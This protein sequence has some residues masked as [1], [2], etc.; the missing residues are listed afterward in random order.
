MG[1]GEAIIVVAAGIGLLFALLHTIGN[2][3]NKTIK[4][5]SSPV[6]LDPGELLK[7]NTISFDRAPQKTFLTLPK[8]SRI[9]QGGQLNFGS[10]TYL[11]GFT[12]AE[13]PLK[14]EQENSSYPYQLTKEVTL[15]TSNVPVFQ[16]EWV[17]SSQQPRYYKVTAGS[18]TFYVVIP[19]ST[20]TEK[21]TTEKAETAVIKVAVKDS[22][23]FQKGQYVHG[24]GTGNNIHGKVIQVNDN[25]IKVDTLV[26]VEFQSIQINGK[27]DANGIRQNRGSI[28]AFLKGSSE[29]V[30][31]KDMTFKNAVLTKDE[32]GV[33]KLSSSS[34]SPD[35]VRVTL[36]DKTEYTINNVTW[37]NYPE[38]ILRRFNKREGDKFTVGE[39]EVSRT[40]ITENKELKS[41]NIGKYT[42][43]QEL[44][45]SGNE[46]FKGKVTKIQPS[47]QGAQSGPGIITLTRQ[48]DERDRG[49]GLSGT[50]KEVADKSIVI[51]LDSASAQKA[52][53]KNI[54][55]MS[56][57][58]TQIKGGGKAQLR[59]VRDAIRQYEAQS[60]ERQLAARRS[61][62][63]AKRRLMASA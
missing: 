16:F 59:A 25:E 14:G 27:V 24:M 35:I 56:S 52:F 53:P 17:G 38:F 34:A 1:P 44:V 28:N 54:L 57:T 37:N 39:K 51:Q 29:V 63:Q 42:I 40:L 3:N 43:G 36:K 22:S 55:T 31:G 30:I 47:T 8:G 12:T 58:A 19:E 2:N 23:T 5:S 4:G 62:N 45:T 21:T 48:R 41:T 33:F 15:N 32:M 49:N 20:T 7:P 26:N 10:T 50:V 13:A 18:T 6:N 60:G 61:F 9:S 46:K 11:R